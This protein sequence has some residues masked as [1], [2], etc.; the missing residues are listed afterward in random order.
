[1]PLPKDSAFAVS[2]K[3]KKEAEL[4]EKMHLKRLVLNYDER[5]RGAAIAE[6]M[7][8]TPVNPAGVKQA[9]IRVRRVL[10]SNSSKRRPG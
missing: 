1:M 2:T 5:E 9:G 7:G 4:E 3:I 8:A 6:A 10:L